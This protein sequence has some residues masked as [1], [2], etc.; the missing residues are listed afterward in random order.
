MQQKKTAPEITQNSNIDNS[1]KPQ[2]TTPPLILLLNANP[3]SSSYT[4]VVQ[5]IFKSF[6]DI[7]EML[8]IIKFLKCIK[9]IAS[10]Q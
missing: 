4:K 2:L 7:K 6:Q 3:D 1:P 9:R 5:T 8:Q 10:S